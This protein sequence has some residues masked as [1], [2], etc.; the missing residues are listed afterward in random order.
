MGV[1]LVTVDLDHRLCLLFGEELRVDEELTDLGSLV[2]LELDDLP[3]LIIL[4]KSAVAGELLRR[5]R[6]KKRRGKRRSCRGNGG[7][8]WAKGRV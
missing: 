8:G 1:D 4:D 6:K 7:R 5:G 2:A 3:R